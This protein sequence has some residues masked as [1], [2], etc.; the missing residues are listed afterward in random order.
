MHAAPT[1]LGA[2]KHNACSMSAVAAAAAAADDD[3]DDDDELCPF[4]R[5]YHL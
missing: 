5:F 4:I 1:C 3:D 2:Y